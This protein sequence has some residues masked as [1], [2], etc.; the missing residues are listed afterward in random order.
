MFICSKCVFFYFLFFLL[1]LKYAGKTCFSGLNFF[2]EI[3]KSYI[4]VLPEHMWEKLI[5]VTKE[6]PI[7]TQLPTSPLPALFAWPVRL[8]SQ[9]CKCVCVDECLIF[10]LQVVVKPSG[11]S[12]KMI[13]YLFRYYRNSFFFFSTQLISTRRKNVIFSVY[14]WPETKVPYWWV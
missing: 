2:F 7:T 5:R 1:L 4:F 14:F 9:F 12:K 6:L 11:H 3:R 10:V 13:K 8:W